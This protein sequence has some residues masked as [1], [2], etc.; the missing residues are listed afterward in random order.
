MPLAKKIQLRKTKIVATLGPSSSRF[1]DIAALYEAGAN[2]FRF[3][4]SHGSHREHKM[5]LD[6]VRQLEREQSHHIG[7]IMDLQGMKLRIGKLTAAT[8]LKPGQKIK[9]DSDPTPGDA[10]RICLPHPQFLRALRPGSDV[11]VDDGRIRLKVTEATGACAEAEVIIG[12][13]ISSHKGV[14]MPGIGLQTPVLTEKDKKDLEFALKEGA[15]WV[16][17]SFVQ[18]PKD[19]EDV[20]QRLAGK[21]HLLTKIENRM[22]IKNLEPIVAASDAVMVARGDLGVELP[23]EEVPIH[24]KHIINICRRAGKP[25]VVATQM[26]DSM[27]RANTPTR[28]ESS[29]VATAVYDGADAVTLSAE[30]AMGNYP[31]EAVAMMHQIIRSVENDDTYRE[32]LKAW[33][34]KTEPTTSDATS[35]AAVRVAQVLSAA[36]IVTYT[37]SGSTAHLVSRERPNITILALTAEEATARQLSIVWGVYCVRARELESFSDMVERACSVAQVE[38]IAKPGQLLA[39]TAGVPFGVPGTTNILRLAQVR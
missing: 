15:D 36:A 28:A 5:R 31:R 39:I 23:P 4:L 30:T 19:I 32:I 34:P 8:W 21:T 29:D 10:K 7:V 12:G 25:V 33:H 26:L 11:L 37:R 22:A 3:N 2:V 9:F 18:T 38:K 14:N 6:F 13:E 17:L 24:Q 1:E 27:V 20:R 35:A 16:A